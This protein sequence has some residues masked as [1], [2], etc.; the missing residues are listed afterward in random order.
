MILSKLS[1]PI[2]GKNKQRLW[3]EMNQYIK[4][5]LNKLVN[6]IDLTMLENIKPCKYSI[7]RVVKMDGGILYGKMVDCAWY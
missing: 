2:P 3:T 7:H 6:N 4:L 1:P 5:P